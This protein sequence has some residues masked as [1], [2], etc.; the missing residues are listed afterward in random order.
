[1]SLISEGNENRTE[2]LTS[3]TKTQTSLHIMD[4]G[5]FTTECLRLIA[6]GEPA[7]GQGSM[8]SWNGRGA[9]FQSHLEKYF[10]TVFCFLTIL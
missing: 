5:V 3:E 6:H 8:L 7:Q 2:A 9:W 4:I 1:M 10:S